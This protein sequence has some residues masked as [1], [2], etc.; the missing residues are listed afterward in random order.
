[1]CVCVLHT[2]KTSVCIS[3]HLKYWNEQFKRLLRFHIST[4]F[5]PMFFREQW[6][7]CRNFTQYSGADILRK[8]SVSTD[9]WVIHPIICENLPPTKNLYTSKLEKT[10]AL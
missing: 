7:T 10:A 3:K 6:K 4:I 1:M 5:E 8:R 2:R 9:P